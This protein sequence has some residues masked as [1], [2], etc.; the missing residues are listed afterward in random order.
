M[1][2]LRHSAV[3]ASLKWAAGRRDVA[4]TIH[5]EAPVGSIGRAYLA[6]SDF[7]TLAASMP[8]MQGAGVDVALARIVVYA[9]EDSP[10]ASLQSGF[11]GFPLPTVFE[12][13][14]TVSTDAT[15]SGGVAL[16][17]GCTAGFTATAPNYVGYLTAAHCSSPHSYWDTTTQ[18]GSSDG[19]A[20]RRITSSRGY[21][22]ISFFSISGNPINDRFFWQ[23]GGT[24]VETGST[25]I[26]IQGNRVYANGQSSGYRYGHITTTSYKPPAC[27]NSVCQPVFVF[28]GVDSL[29][30]DSG[31]PW[32]IQTNRPVG[33][34]G[35]SSST[36]S[37]Y[38]K[39]Q[40]RPSGSNI[41]TG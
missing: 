10:D 18:S 5:D 34:H 17:A 21:A 29:G 35:G 4:L 11:E 30:G 25:A 41:W 33:I 39:L 31:G 15:I 36:H 27:G 19:Q 14:T 23:Q 2:A 9:T 38:S 20:T 40:Y 7:N 24:T 8:T 22:D 1:L 32:Y 6:S 37:Y 12:Q 3:V 13:M 16:S 28:V 26:P